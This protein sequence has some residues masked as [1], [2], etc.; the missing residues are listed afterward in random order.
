MVLRKLAEALRGQNWF[1]VL[2]EV[3]IVVVGI[4]IGLQAND[5][6][7]ARIDRA[8]EIRYLERLQTDLLTDMGRL[9]RGEMLAKQRIRQVE[10]LLN[11]I[12]NPEVVASQPSQFVQA[13]EKVG[14]SSYRPLTPNAYS[15]LVSTGRTT[16]IRSESIRDALV[17]YY[18]RIDFWDGLMSQASFVHDFYMASA[19]VLN[20]D[21]LAA[22]EQSVRDSTEFV[23]NADD[24]VIIAEQL[25]MRPQG[26]RL[27]PKI[28]QGHELVITVV[29]EHRERNEALQMAIEKYLKGGGDHP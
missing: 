14:W 26:T 15:E 2:L 3:L 4:F 23:V 5:W 13:V 22:I 1:T 6:N 27:L 18:G 29:A 11:G 24:A 12:A 17:E 7:Q 28:Y 16:L 20:Q 10:L 8:D 9:D 19:G 25:N 21:Q